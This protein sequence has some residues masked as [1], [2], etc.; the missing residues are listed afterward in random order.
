MSGDVRIVNLEGGVEFSML[1]ENGTVAMTPNFDTAVKLSLFG[2]NMLDDGSADSVET[3][4]GNLLENEPQFKL[5]SRTQYLLRSLPA[6]SS[7]LNVIEDA[8]RSDLAWFVSTGIAN[9]I[10]DVRVTIPAPNTIKITGSVKAV[11]VEASFSFTENWRASTGAGAPAAGIIAPPITPPVTGKSLVLEAASI[12]SATEQP[13]SIANDWAAMVWM[14]PRP[15]ATAESVLRI[16]PLLGNDHRISVRTI[17]PGT[18]ESGAGF[19]TRLDTHLGAI[20]NYRFE[21]VL[22]FDEWSCL[23]VTW[24]GA[25]LSNYVNGVKLAPTSIAVDF[26]GT[27]TNAARTVRF[28]GAAFNGTVHQGALWNTSITAA[29]VLTVYNGGDTGLDLLKDRG[30]YVSSGNLVHWYQL[31]L[32][33][34]DIGFDYATIPAEVDLH[35]LETLTDVSVDDITDDAPGVSS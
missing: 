1:I 20:R 12:E 4:W 2:G 14:R 15:D 27:M 6:T 24:D 16:K 19:D 29:E 31:G 9:S 11:G 18:G 25:V 21:N 10:E 3:W 23:V 32:N 35:P 34:D 7:N 28:G 17:R 13:L 33:A 30:D 5:V 22:P 8:V 26:A